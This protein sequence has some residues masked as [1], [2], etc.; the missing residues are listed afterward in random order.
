MGRRWRLAVVAGMFALVT[1]CGSEGGDGDGVASVSE[2][3]S[4][5]EAADRQ[6]AD[7]DGGTDED[8]MRA[9]AKCMR[10]HG[11]DVP[12][13]EPGGGI[14]VPAE[15]ADGSGSKTKGAHEACK[16]LLPN[17][18]E[19]PKPTAEDLDEMREQAK[20][21]REHGLDVP[22]PTMDEPYIRLKDNGDHEQS[23]KAMEECM[24]AEG[25]AVAVPGNGSKGAVTGGGK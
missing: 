2:G 24:G 9:F 10:E 1:A 17:G 12:D 15:K 22:D 25:G 5:A 8:K 23:K 7:Q 4:A 18:G 19:P 21:L 14:A 6:G 16:E 11:V 3:D 20:C 13:P